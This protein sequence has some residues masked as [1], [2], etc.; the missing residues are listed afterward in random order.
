MT[1]PFT[2]AQVTMVPGVAPTSTSVP[3]PPVV[4]N[5]NTPFVQEQYFTAEQMA[6]ARQQEKDKLYDA[7]KKLQ[8][9]VANFKLELDQYK[10]ERETAQQEAEQARQA[11]AEAQRL[12][13][14]ERLSVKE[15]LDKRSLELQ[16]QQEEFQQQMMLKQTL[17]DRDQELF[18]VKTFAQ[19]RVQ[20]ELAQN[21]IIP[22]LVE[23]IDGNTEEEIEFSITKAK[24]KTASIV[25]GATRMVSPNPSGQPL[26]PAMPGV[27]PTGFAPTGP[28]DNLNGTEQYSVDDI[29]NMSNAEYAAFRAKVGV[30][31]AGNNKGLFN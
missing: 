10:T 27:S 7:Q 21:S 13:E 26:T 18:R 8:D 4:I 15:L 16:H 22:D 11:A 19:R 24:E 9:Q 12:A 25:A 14:E 28:L 29:K 5:T 3:N 1:T 2:D 30:D 20:E 31:K 6:A 23:Y 17:M